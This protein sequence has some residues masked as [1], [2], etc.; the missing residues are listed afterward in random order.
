MSNHKRAVYAILFLL[1]TM[2]LLLSACSGSSRNQSEEERLKEAITIGLIARDVFED[3]EE[4]DALE[5]GVVEKGDIL[6]TAALR[7]RIDM[8]VKETLRFDTPEGRLRAIHVS[9]YDIVSEGDLLAE[10]EYD[11]TSLIVERDVLL[12]TMEQYELRHNADNAIRLRT[13]S[14][15]WN[16]YN[17]STNQYDREVI[18]LNISRLEL[19]YTQ[20]LE[21][22]AQTMEDYEEQLAD[23]EVSLRGELL[24]APFD[25]IVTN[26][27]DIS[28]GS[29]VRWYDDILTL[30]DDSKLQFI[31]VEEPSILR[32]GDIV[33]AVRQ[34]TQSDG[35]VMIDEFPMRVVS[36]P[37]VNEG[38]YMTYDILLTMDDMD[39]FEQW[40]VDTDTTR[41]DLVLMY[42]SGNT[43]AFEALDVVLVP[44]SALYTENDDRYVF[45]YEDGEIRKR[46][47]TTGLGTPA[48]TQVLQGLEPGQT[49][50]LR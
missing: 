14:D 24:F 27:I 18:R 31:A 12:F 4:E 39:A 3:E 46:Y 41:R 17:R 22:A 45:L 2:S 10:I 34:F 29:V 43:L 5:L 47:I 40:M 16:N 26:I 49:V 25:G 15:L 23:L 7:I 11:T 44:T 6:R 8:P 32:R 1:F 50:V 28:I 48:F 38:R 21:E 33:T 9:N 37:L 35:T 13:I 19:L 36:D 42:F 20:F 30:I